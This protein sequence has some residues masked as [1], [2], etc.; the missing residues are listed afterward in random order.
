MTKKPTTPKPSAI[1]PGEHTMIRQLAAF[2]ARVVGV[3]A[4]VWLLVDGTGLSGASDEL[5]RDEYYAL[6][7]SS[8]FSDA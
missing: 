5:L 6:R 1:Q 3:L 4:I 7:A 8:R 2:A